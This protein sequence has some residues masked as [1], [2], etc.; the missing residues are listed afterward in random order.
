MIVKE[1]I[2]LLKGM[3]ENSIVIIQK[4][5][6]GNGY[7]PLASVDADAIYVAETTWWGEIYSTKWTAKEAG[8]YSEEEWEKF[9]ENTPKCVVLEPVN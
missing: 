4:D 8:M 6:E 2:E 1:F 7:S 5:S 9:K 3:P